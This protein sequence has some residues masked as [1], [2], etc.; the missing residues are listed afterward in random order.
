MARVGRAGGESVETLVFAGAVVVIAVLLVWWGVFANRLIDERSDLGAQ[1]AHATMKDPAF[2]AQAL[3]DHEAVADRQRVM[4]LGEGAVFGAMLLVCAGVLFLMARESRR[5]AQRLVRLLQFTTHELKT[6]IAG[7]RALLQSLQLGSIPA[8]ARARF[9]DQGLLECNRLEHLAETILAFQRAASRARLNPTRA[10]TDVLITDVLEHR[11]RTF[12][13]AEE[14]VRHGGR[15]LDIVVD[16]DAFRVVLENL[17]DNARKYGGARV[18]MSESAAGG[19]WRLELKDQG[20]GFEPAE[21]ERLFE[22]FERDTREG[23][24]THGSGLGLHIS[25]QL[26]RD[27]GGELSATSEGRGR[28]AVFVVE[29][30]LFASVPLAGGTAGADAGATRNDRGGSHD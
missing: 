23:V 8:D 18:E 5:S 7:V 1:L 28:G 27:M 13:G 15:P 14:V 11:K 16:R 6:P 9:L 17:L 10:S 3:A 20:V 26:V 2:L 12:G 25:R 22:P 30:P 29:L 19:R 21:G 24:S 4:I